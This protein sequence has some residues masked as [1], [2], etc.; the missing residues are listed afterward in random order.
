MPIDIQDLWVVPEAA[1]PSTELGDMHGFLEE[2]QDSEAGEEPPK[3][4]Q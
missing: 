1:N 3:L 2:C 4:L